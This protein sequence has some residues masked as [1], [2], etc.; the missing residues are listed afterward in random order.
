MRS[1]TLLICALLLAAC[2]SPSIERQEA[3]AEHNVPCNR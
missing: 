2:A 3:A 1:V